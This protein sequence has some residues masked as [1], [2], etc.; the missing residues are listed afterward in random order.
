MGNIM[1]ITWIESMSTAVVHLG[2]AMYDS[3]LYQQYYLAHAKYC[4]RGPISV[5]KIELI[6]RAASSD[7]TS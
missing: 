7:R 2:T 3:D 4:T 5:W 6:S 1:Q